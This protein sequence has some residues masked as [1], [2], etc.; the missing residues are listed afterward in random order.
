MKEY[1][2]YQWSADEVV[3]HFESDA[4]K[5]I[6]QTK[7]DLRLKQNGPNSLD[8]VRP[9]SFWLILLRQ[10]SNFFII[11]LFFAAIISY[12]VDGLF[13]A[14]FLLAIVLINVG[15]GF[16]QEYKA[17]KS[18]TELKKSYQ[19]NT[20]V[21]RDGLAKNVPNDMLVVGDLV[22]ITAGN[23]VP[24]DLRIINSES[25]SID[26]SAL[27]GES[28]AVDKLDNIFPL[29]TKL[30]DR[31]NMAYAG[32]LAVAGHGRGIVVA[33]GKA[34]E[35]GKIA[36]LVE[37]SEEKTPLEQQIAY[38]GK[39]LGI[40]ALILALLIFCFGYIRQVEV[41]ELLTFTIA[42][43]IGM[44]PESLPTAITLALSLGVSRM[45]QQKAIVRRLAV[46]ETLGSVNI[47]ASDKT[48]TLTKNQLEVEKVY[49]LKD[50]DL[51]DVFADKKNYDQTKIDRFLTEALVC[52]NINVHKLAKEDFVGD[53]LDEAIA[54]K[55]EANDKNFDKTAQKFTRLFEIPF[56]SLKK[57]MAVIVQEGEEKYVVSKGSVE[58][59]IEFSSLNQTQ[60]NKIHQLNREL[61]QNGYKVIALA[62]KKTSSQSSTGILK[63]M[64]F[65]G[66]IAFSDEVAPGVKEAIER[67]QKAGVRPV[68][69]TGDHPET[70]TYIA[71]EVGLS[72]AKDEVILED[73]FFALNK[74]EQ[75]EKL[76][77]IK[78]F[79]RVTPEGKIKI[80]DVFR[81]ADFCVAVT[82]DGTNDAPAL[83][84]A[85]VGLAMGVRGTDVAKDAADIVLADDKYGTI[86]SAIEYGRA[87]YDNIR[88]VIIIL[89]AGNFNE[90]ILIV[91]AFIFN[92]PIPLTTVQILWV[93][94]IS[95]NI[96]ALTLCFEKPRVDILRDKPRS[97]KT[98]SIKS[99]ISFTGQLSLVSLFFSVTLFVWGLKHSIAEARTMVFFFIVLAELS[100]AFSVR[101]EKRI[102]QNLRSFFENKYL[103]TS[104]ILVL[105]AQSI[106]FVPTI[107]KFFGIVRLSGFEFL[108]LGLCVAGA[109]VSAEI[110]HY[111]YHKK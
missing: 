20:L 32:T 47:I 41:L 4:E 2:Y 88:N 38:L 69:I 33:T 101:S 10:F 12:Y 98:D 72:V 19:A 70:A 29:E 75:K 106:L 34:T 76:N 79:A 59:I 105:L 6:T 43:F 95:E 66:L 91:F 64:D 13:Q 45:A 60:K 40:V 74:K 52:S 100:Y 26:E 31:K 111:F 77:S 21:I 27:T 22:E 24:A 30:A 42:L 58:K 89:L 85:D 103:V 86:I 11:L 94:M 81:S 14:L 82:G 35:F 54:R 1:A 15:L 62:V 51:I 107:A 3:S 7:A 68:M 9:V 93:N 36:N 102:W 87:I 5:G 17:E 16:F 92:L 65:R 73:D 57:Y 99:I 67:A 44:V 25:L 97:A 37:T 46:I 53:P 71:N 39:I 84:G 63:N 104:S 110:L 18:I 61:A 56:D 108:I 48:G 90:V 55:A 96:S 49:I 8:T 50:A 83:K 80:V 28:L 78:I 23:K 109:F